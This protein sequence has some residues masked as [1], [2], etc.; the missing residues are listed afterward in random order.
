MWWSTS[1]SHPNSSANISRTRA[2]TSWNGSVGVSVAGNPCQVADFGPGSPTPIRARNSRWI[3][4]TASP[5]IVCIVCRTRASHRT[6][7]VPDG[8]RGDHL[9]GGIRQAQDGGVV[10]EVDAD[11]ARRPR[12][13][14]E[15]LRGP[16]PAAGGALRGDGD[17]A[18]IEQATEDVR[19]GRAGEPQRLG[20]LP[21]GELP[22]AMQQ[23]Q[24]V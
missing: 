11:E 6:G 22:A 8:R 20:D 3:S 24:H 1:T 9:S 16:A 14:A 7:R 18:L 2:L 12:V 13:D 10:A 23:R 17:D 15:H 5:R 21:S 19:D 4:P